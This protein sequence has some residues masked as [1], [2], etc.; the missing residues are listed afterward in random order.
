MLKQML[1]AILRIF[2]YNK[3]VQYTIWCHDN[4]NTNQWIANVQNFRKQKNMLFYEYNSKNNLP[5]SQTQMLSVVLEA[6][7]L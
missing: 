1:L 4:L 3:A 5:H 7:F 6:S 2:Q